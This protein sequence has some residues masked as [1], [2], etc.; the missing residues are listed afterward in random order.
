[1]FDLSQNFGAKTFITAKI[2]QF[3]FVFGRNLAWL[4]KSCSRILLGREFG[5]QVIT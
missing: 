1:M 5:K 2:H 4:R 3:P